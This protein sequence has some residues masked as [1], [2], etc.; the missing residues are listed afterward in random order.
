LNENFIDQKGISNFDDFHTESYIAVSSSKTGSFR[1]CCF[2]K[3]QHRLLLLNLGSLCSF[4]CG[5]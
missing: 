5:S 4:G 2:G 3:G 1:A